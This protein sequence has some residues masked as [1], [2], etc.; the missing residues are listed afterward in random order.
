MQGKS[1]GNLQKPPIFSIVSVT[2]STEPRTSPSYSLLFKMPRIHLC[3][4]VGGYFLCPSPR[5]GKAHFAH[6][7]DV[8]QLRGYKKVSSSQTTQNILFY[9]K[10]KFFGLKKIHH[11]GWAFQKYL[12]DLRNVSQLS[13][14]LLA[15]EKGYHFSRKKLKHIWKVSMLPNTA[16]K[17][18]KIWTQ[19]LSI[20]NSN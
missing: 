16:L 7:H 1:T 5:S 3:N 9:R 12:Y 14:K 8:F 10:Q 18:H 15:F 4:K 19:L 17:I 11:F 6:C 13:P 20:I 2:Y